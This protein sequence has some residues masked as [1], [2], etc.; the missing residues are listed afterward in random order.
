[1]TGSCSSPATSRCLRL[2][3]DL[4]NCVAHN[5][6]LI[7]V[8]GRDIMV[9]GV[10][11][12]RRLECSISPTRRSPIE[13]AFFDRGP[14]DPKQLFLGGYWSAYWFNGQ[15]YASEI[16]RGLDVFKLKPSEF[17]SQN[18]ITA[19]TLAHTDTFNPQQQVRVTWPATAVVGRAYLDQLARSRALPADRITAIRTALDR[20]ENLS[21]KSPKA[22]EAAT[23][24]EMLASQLESSTA[25]KTGAD[26]ARASA[27]ASLLTTRAAA[28]RQS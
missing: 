27:L 7:P 12:G 3:T 14:L 17:L 26:K 16:A 22:A 1:M 24:L 23:Q 21:G 5:G 11:P 8:P 20:A 6:S 19:A 13:I 28:L 10:V 2:Q 15:I 9:A 4:E 18:E 25:A